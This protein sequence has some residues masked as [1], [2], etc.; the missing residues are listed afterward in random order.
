MKIGSLVELI[1]DKWHTRPWLGEVYPIKGVIYTIREIR[2]VGGV[3]VLL[4][5]II[6]PTFPPPDD[7]EV[8]F[9]I[10]RFRELQPPMHLAD[11]IFSHA[12]ETCEA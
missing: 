11:E 6:N 7:Y 10:E 5:E 3:G 9:K 2:H 8:G 12:P 1:N 4:E